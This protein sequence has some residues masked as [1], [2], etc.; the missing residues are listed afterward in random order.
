MDFPDTVKYQKSHEWARKESGIIVCGISD[1]AQDSLGDVVYVELP[2]VGAALKQ[3]ESFGTIE[4]V[5]AASDVY[6]PVDGEILEINSDLEDSSSL[7][8]EDPYGKGW[9][10]KIKPADSAQDDGLMDAA[11][12]TSYTET[13]ED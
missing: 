11:A 2:E 5:K 12:Y 6:M 13:L 4:S 1:Y 8:N 7:V 9:L 10:V 3:G